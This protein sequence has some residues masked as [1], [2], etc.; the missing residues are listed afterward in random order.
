MLVLTVE[1]SVETERQVKTGSLTGRRD[2]R[3][4]IYVPRGTFMNKLGPDELR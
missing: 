3:C 1:I 2:F 4:S